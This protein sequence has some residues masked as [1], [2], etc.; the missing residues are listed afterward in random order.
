MKKSQFYAL[1]IV[2][3]AGVFTAT[4]LA[5][6]DGFQRIFDGKSFAGW[7]KSE[8]NPSSWQIEDGILVTKG[9]RSHL[10]YDTG[11]KPL[12]NFHLKLE[13]MTEPGSNG[14]IF[15]HTAYQAHG[16]PQKGFE[17]QVN[18]S[19]KD[20]RKT[21][22]IYGVADLGHTPA[23]DDQW[24]TQEII[25]EG[26]QVTVKIDGIAVIVYSEPKGA[27]PGERFTRA[28]DEGTIALQAHDPDSVVRYRNIQLKRLPE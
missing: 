17:S 1:L 9:P 19:H 14:G 3:A 6:E 18:V 26:K 16:W 11:N 28:F 15:F 22:S 20:W 4:N 24:W 27:T 8:E 12:R 13:V 25:V 7:V 21:G 5:A 10:F 2:L 23:R